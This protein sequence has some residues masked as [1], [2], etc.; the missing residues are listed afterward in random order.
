MKEQKKR[1]RGKKKQIYKGKKLT[2]CIEEGWE[3][4]NG[5]MRKER[6]HNKKNLSDNKRDERKKRKKRKEEYISRNVE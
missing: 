5:R 4:S 2:V 3:R 6:N 1:I